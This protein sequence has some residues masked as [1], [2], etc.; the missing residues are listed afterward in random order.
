MG[1]KGGGWVERVEV[2]WEGWRLGRKDGGWVGRTE[3]GEKGERWVGIVE[4]R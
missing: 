2:G 3:V 1:G 4:F